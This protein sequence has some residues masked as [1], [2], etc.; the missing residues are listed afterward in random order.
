MPWFGITQ[1]CITRAQWGLEVGPTKKSMQ[2]FFD[3]T[4][5]GRGLV[6]SQTESCRKPSTGEIGVREDV[7]DRHRQWMPLQGKQECRRMLN[8]KVLTSRHPERLRLSPLSDLLHQAWSYSS[9]TLPA[10]NRPSCLPAGPRPTFTSRPRMEMM[11]HR[12]RTASGF[13]WWWMAAMPGW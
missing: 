9:S 3:L 7:E 1:F 10:K 4:H 2:T 11:T 13:P 8:V 5:I 12:W 6:F